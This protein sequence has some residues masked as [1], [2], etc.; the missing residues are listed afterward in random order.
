MSAH[1]SLGPFGKG[2]PLA[3]L[4]LTFQKD[5]I[6]VTFA[7]FDH[8]LEC[9][10]CTWTEE[11]EPN[12]DFL[13]HCLK[14]LS[15]LPPLMEYPQIENLFSSSWF[16][17]GSCDIIFPTLISAALHS[18]LEGHDS[19]PIQYC[20]ICR[21]FLNA[22]SLLNHLCQKHPYFRCPFCPAYLQWL[23]L[24]Q[25]LL[26]P[27][28]HQ[29]VKIEDML[30][31][32]RACQ[33]E[34]IIK[35][36]S[37]LMFK[38]C[39][40][41]DLLASAL[42]ITVIN[43][44]SI[45]RV[46]Q[47]Y[48]SLADTP[49]TENFPHN[50]SKLVT[51]RANTKFQAAQNLIPLLQVLDRDGF[52]HQHKQA[53]THFAYEL[54]QISI[55]RRLNFLLAH[56]TTY[57]QEHRLNLFKSNAT[58]PEEILLP[59]INIDDINTIDTLDMS[60]VAVILVGAKHLKNFGTHLSSQYY[61]LNLSAPGLALHPTQ[62]FRNHGGMKFTGLIPTKEWGTIPVLSHHSF[63]HHL[64]RVAKALRNELP[65]VVEFDISS[66]LAC[67]A[68]MRFRTALEIE[69]PT[70]ILAYFA[71]FRLLLDSLPNQQAFKDN[72]L[73]IGQLPFAIPNMSPSDLIMLW[74]RID[75]L[76]ANLAA[77]FRIIYVPC[78]KSVGI[79]MTEYS[80]IIPEPGAV[81]KGNY[82][83]TGRTQRQILTFIEQM[84]DAVTKFRRHLP[85][86]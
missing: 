30:K 32:F 64:E 48:M 56:S 41:Q 84:C 16:V 47:P 82:T 62:T 57:N 27:L 36:R 59:P 78:F 65:I 21:K 81:F 51:D 66:F 50:L 23:A 83:Y 71:H 72:Y 43:N 13:S 12:V 6:R 53:L 19:Q 11:T 10:V 42:P 60:N 63:F 14:H 74:K 73:V 4:S 67:I 29:S 35:S 52:L 7:K 3:S 31:H 38:S 39:S 70:Y 76:A 80:L 34:V 69:I 79:T 2:H 75:C 9:R 1:T 17:C 8:K 33:H 54:G 46:S 20:A 44:N 45:L 24:L 68:G 58:S 22:T 40:T 85:H 86:N 55:Y 37:E 26:S 49:D 5:I 18:F 15:T 25:H 61:I 77:V 28:E